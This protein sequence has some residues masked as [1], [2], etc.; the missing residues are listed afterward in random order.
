[1]K[2]LISILNN[3]MLFPVLLLVLTAIVLSSIVA[4]FFIG[5]D[6][7]M[8]IMS[9]QADTIRKEFHSLNTKPLSNDIGAVL[10]K[11]IFVIISFP[12]AVFIALKDNIR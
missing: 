12:V 1:M 7:I 9:Q 8:W 6:G 10:Y 11:V 2:T 4:Y 3:V 5:F